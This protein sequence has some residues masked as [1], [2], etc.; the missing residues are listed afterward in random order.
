VTNVPS[1]AYN[2]VGGNVEGKAQGVNVAV[3]LTVPEGCVGRAEVR[4]R[5]KCHG[6]FKKLAS[7]L[8]DM[9]G[10]GVFSVSASSFALFDAAHLTGRVVAFGFCVASKTALTLCSVARLGFSDGFDVVIHERRC[11]M[12]F[13]SMACA[14]RRLRRSRAPEEEA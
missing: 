1:S 4:V 5:V 3:P 13:L 10:S 12:K 7:I 9:E 11:L 2:K 8:E 14:F 6:A